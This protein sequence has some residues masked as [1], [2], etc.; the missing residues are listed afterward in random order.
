MLDAQNQIFNALF[1]DYQLL[2]SIG[3]L[4]FDLKAPHPLD[5]GAAANRFVRLDPVQILT[6]PFQPPL[7]RGPS[8]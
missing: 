7:A 6:D 2:P 4:L 8:R 5:A 3:S 1:T